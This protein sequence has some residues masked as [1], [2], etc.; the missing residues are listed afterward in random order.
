METV[1]GMWSAYE[2]A[3]SK[4]FSNMTISTGLVVDMVDRITELGKIIAEKQDREI[5]VI[6]KI[7]SGDT[8]LANSYQ[9]CKELEDELRDLRDVIDYKNSIISELDLENIK[10]RE[11]FGV[12]L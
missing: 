3:K 7:S 10:L 4:P 12:K 5:Q 9:K 8:V 6:H 1:F 2:E 11:M